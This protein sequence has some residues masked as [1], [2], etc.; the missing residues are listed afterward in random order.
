MDSLKFNNDIFLKNG[1]LPHNFVAE[2]TI[3]SSLLISSEAIEK[4]NNML[5]VDAF[6]FK[7]H[8]EIYK[9]II[10]LYDK[11][12][13]VDILV[14]I[15]YLQDNGILEKIGGIQ[16]LIELLNQAPNLTYFEEYLSLVKEK[17]LRRC[18]IKIGYE[19]ISSSYITNFPLE[20]ILNESEEKIYNLTTKTHNQNL[21][22]TGELIDTIFF[23]LKEKSLNPSLSGL[24]SGFPKL[25]SLTLGFQKSDLIILAGRPS[26]GKTALSLNIVT[27]ILK[28]SK[29]SILFF[30]MEMSKEQIMYR[31]ISLIAQ[32]NQIRLKTG[33]LNK[34]DWVKILKTFQI[35]SKLPLFID[36]TTN[37]SISNIKS[38][39]KTVFFEQKN[40][41]LVVIDYL[42]LM[43][44]DGGKTENRAQ[45]ISQITQSLKALAREFNIPIIVLSQLSRNVES[46]VDKRPVLSDLRDSG[47]IEQDADLVLMLY[48]NQQLSS[49]AIELILAK[50]RNGR[51]GTVQL[52]IA[53]NGIQFLNDN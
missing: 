28:K 36:D 12:G 24:I 25:D 23:E 44:I 46:R 41:S 50:H 17:F 34:T 4:A 13:H 5:T 10:S 33:K 45:E 40:I 26:M 38:K 8:Q 22:S 19:L 9:V 35:L 31:L 6:Y 52:S 48:K 49:S 29:L 7:N 16:V 1:Q 3:L 39:I 51:T 37:L 42:Q 32:I 11:K 30:S 15:A 43:R 53:K 2:Q 20:T 21:K 27:N 14:L 47:S 18:L